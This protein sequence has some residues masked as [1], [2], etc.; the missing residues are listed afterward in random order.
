MSSPA[1]VTG[2][3]T[4]SARAT[5]VRRI[6]PRP[7]RGD[8]TATEAGPAPAATGAAAEPTPAPAAARV[9]AAPHRP[10]SRHPP[11]PRRLRPRPTATRCLDPNRNPD[12]H[13][14]Q[15]P[16]IVVIAGTRIERTRKVS[17]STPSATATPI[18]NRI[19]S[20]AVAIDPNV[21]ARIRPADVMTAPVCPDAIRTA[22]RIGRVSASSRIRCI[23]K[24]L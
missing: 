15:S 21:P 9:T 19:I 11:P 10:P 23:R 18:W 1:T 13:Q 22:S 7:E 8:A 16:A 4:A 5:A 6:D 14:A 3:R 20:G 24:M 17:I 2:I 12:G